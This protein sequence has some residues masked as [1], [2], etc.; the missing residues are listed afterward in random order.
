MKKLNF[1]KKPK[2]YKKHVKVARTRKK[3]MQIYKVKEL[4]II[5]EKKI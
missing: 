2:T 5:S 1:N 4:K 3:M